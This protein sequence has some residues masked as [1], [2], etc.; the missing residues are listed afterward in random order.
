MRPHVD[1]DGAVVRADAALD[2][3]EGLGHDLRFREDLVTS[4]EIPDAHRPRLDAG[5]QS[6]AC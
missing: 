5:G 1:T 6:G 4:K 3:A 2:A